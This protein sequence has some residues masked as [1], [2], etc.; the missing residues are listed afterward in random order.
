MDACNGRSTVNRKRET[1]REAV[2]RTARAILLSNAGLPRLTRLSSL[3]SPSMSAHAQS[4]SDANSLIYLVD[5]EE[6]LLNLAED[7][8][9]PDGYRLKK[10][11]DPAAA[12]ESFQREPHKPELLLTDYAMAPLNG[13][14]LSTMCKSAH[15]GLKILM[16]SGTA[17]PEIVDT[18][19]GAIDH[20]I[21]KPYRP[22][23]LARTVRSLLG[24]DTV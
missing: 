18:A 4:S 6:L 15:P 16:V 19:P 8:L 20:F 5:D 1:G 11:V 21:A 10:F 24:N 7:S 2:V 23:D 14:E 3:R 17:G 12:L 9:S 22:A 13:I